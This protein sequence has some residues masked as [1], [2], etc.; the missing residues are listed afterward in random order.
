[1]SASEFEKYEGLVA[2]VRSKLSIPQKIE[3]YGLWC[4]A[5][6]G[7]CTRKQPSRARLLEYGKWAAWKKYEHLGKDRARERFVEKAKELLTKTSSKL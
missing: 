6:R 4:V 3:M 1:M 7:A 2:K 5:T